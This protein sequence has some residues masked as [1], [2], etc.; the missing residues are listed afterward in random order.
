LFGDQRQVLMDILSNL[1]TKT[2]E[3][4][5]AQGGDQQR[6]QQQEENEADA[7]NRGIGRGWSPDGG[8]GYCF[9]RW[10]PCR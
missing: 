9:M 1:D 6:G 7:G 4:G 2:E 10:K 8:L 5:R 3:G